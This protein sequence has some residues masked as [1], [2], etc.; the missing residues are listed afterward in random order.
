MIVLIGEGCNIYAHDKVRFFYALS[1]AC[2]LSMH[3]YDAGEKGAIEI[4]HDSLR[5]NLSLYSDSVRYDLPVICNAATCRL[6]SL[7]D[8]KLPKLRKGSSVPLYRNRNRLYY[9]II[10]L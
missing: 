3:L 1:S 4:A 9:S 10:V 2:D 8:M 6:I 5:K 7:G